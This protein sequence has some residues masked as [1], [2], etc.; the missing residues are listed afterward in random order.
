[1]FDAARSLRDR[2]MAVAREAARIV[3]QTS[4]TPKEVELELER[5]LRRAFD[6]FEQHDLPGLVERLAP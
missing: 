1:V 2:I 4:G 5:E 3:A 6:Q